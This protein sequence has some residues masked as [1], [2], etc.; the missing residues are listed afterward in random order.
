MTLVVVLHQFDWSPD[1][2]PNPITIRFYPDELP[3]E[4]DDDLAATAIE[5]GLVVAVE[6]DA[7]AIGPD[8]EAG[9]EPDED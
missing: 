1:D 8:E 5:R 2:G 6:D 9:D 4:I 7:E 3:V